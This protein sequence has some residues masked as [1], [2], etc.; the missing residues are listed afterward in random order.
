LIL[1]ELVERKFVKR[2]SDQEFR[3]GRAAVRPWLC[4]EKILTCS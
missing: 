1:D 3:A 2:I 4:H